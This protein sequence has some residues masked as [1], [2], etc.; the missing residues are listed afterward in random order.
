MGILV[1]T[2]GGTIGALPYEDPVH[3]PDYC[4]TLPEGC[5]P[6]REAIKTAFLA[7]ETRCL[8][9]DPRDSKLIDKAYRKK[10]L[11]LMARAPEKAILIT[12]GTGT[13]LDTAEFFYQSFM[14]DASLKEKRVVLTGAMTPLANG[15]GS[16]G[17]LNLAFSLDCLS[18]LSPDLEKVNI[19]LCDFDAKGKWTPHLYPFKPNQYE[20]F[21][22]A[23]GRYHRLKKRRG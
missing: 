13:I 7:T 11:D 6:V 3:P 22:D 18:R 12:H 9:L 4:S 21:Y 10:I 2:T 23:D 16:D 15:K 5:D 1:I 19:V 17:H 8:S 20:K 14:E